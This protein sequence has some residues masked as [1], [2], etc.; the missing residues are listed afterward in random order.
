MIAFLYSLNVVALLVS[1]M[2]GM[3]MKFRALA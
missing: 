1:K 2:C 3:E